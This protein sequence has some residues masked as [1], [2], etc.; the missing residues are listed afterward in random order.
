MT[1]STNINEYHTQ[2]MKFTL[3][4]KVK[5]VQEEELGRE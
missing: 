5:G 4:M 1:Y 2:N 3:G